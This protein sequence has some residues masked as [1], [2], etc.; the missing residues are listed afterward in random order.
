MKLELNLSLMEKNDAI[1]AGI[2]AELAAKQVYCIN[3]IGSPGAG[4]TSLLERL[5][6]HLQLKTAV[7]EG[8]L[9]T[10]KDAQRISACAIPA[11]QINTDGGCHLDAAMIKKVLPVFDLAKTDLLVIENV[12]N[13]V[14]P[15]GFDLGEDLR[16][17]LLSLAEGGDKPAKYPATFLAADLVLL[18]K[19]DL[20]PL[21]DV[22]VAEVKAEIAAINPKAVIMEVCCR[23]NHEQGIGEVAALLQQ[24]CAAKQE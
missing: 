11:V 2:R 1:A 13:L 17:V 5:L 10:A 6:P 14:C 19:V 21:C 24:R 18:N 9:A 22:D 23:K 7:I 20:A 15:T 12:G 8:D 4:K 3:I 16:V